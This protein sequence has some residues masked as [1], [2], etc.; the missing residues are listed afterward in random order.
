MVAE[1]NIDLLDGETLDT[2]K[3][4][5]LKIIQ[6]RHGYRFSID[7]LLLCAFTKVQN[8]ER[9]LD[10]GCGSGIIALLLAHWYD[11][12]IVVGAEVQQRQAERARRNV[13]I[14]ALT[15]R[16]SI[17]HTDLRLMTSSFGLFDRVVA[18]PPFRPLGT[19]RCS[20]G[21]ER[22]ASRHELSG[23]LH[24]FINCGA[25]ML[26][27]GGS[28]SMIH[29]AERLVDI[30]ALMRKA[31]LEP[32]RIRFVHSRTG[33]AARLVLVEGR[34]GGRPDAVIMAPLYVYDGDDY[35]DEV[36]AIYQR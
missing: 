36:A 11:D 32:K 4:G 1:N 9:I 34:K 5:T 28:M 6:H 10:L 29:L 25:R 18:N 31:S 24:D 27:H 13:F 19:G 23:G 22:A 3:G 12:C 21:D 35:S 15:E 20:S 8:S 33:D 17:K 7:P 14:N 2:L 16:V 26:R 30:V